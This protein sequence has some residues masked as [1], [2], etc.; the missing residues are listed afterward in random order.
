[1]NFL[2]PALLL[3]IYCF[4]ITLQCCLT[5]PTQSLQPDK[6]AINSKTHDE[7]REH[8]TRDQNADTSASFRVIAM[9]EIVQ[10]NDIDTGLYVTVLKD[11]NQI[12]LSVGGSVR[13][14]FELITASNVDESYPS[15]AWVIRSLYQTNKYLCQ[16]NKGT[17]YLSKLKKRCL[18]HK[19]LSSRGLSFFNYYSWTKFIVTRIGDNQFVSKDAVTTGKMDII[20]APWTLKVI[21][22]KLALE[23]HEG[24]RKLSDI[25]KGHL[26]KSQDKS[27]TLVPLID[28]RKGYIESTKVTLTKHDWLKA[29]QFDKTEHNWNSIITNELHFIKGFQNDQFIYE[30]FEN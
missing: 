9:D 27:F 7:S 18:L 19:V 25:I 26:D 14:L 10:L 28:P 13:S 11:S 30:D 16:K 21:V 3:S 5:K 1:M 8:D 23:L 12:E 22:T 29:S 2:F 24:T 4:I 20:P 15:D 6:V 17:V